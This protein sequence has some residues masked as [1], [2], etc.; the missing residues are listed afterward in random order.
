MLDEIDYKFL[1]LLQ[2]D[3]RMTQQEIADA[4]GLSQSAVAQRLRKLETQSVITGYVAQVDA[5]QLGKDI[6]A[7]IGVGIE[8]PRFNAG[9]AK[10]MIALP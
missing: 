5:H 6:T 2:R 8:H 7:F 9:F 10:K 4:V 1:E 3:A